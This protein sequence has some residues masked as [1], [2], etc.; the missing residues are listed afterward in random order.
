M[1]A[2]NRCHKRHGCR[3]VHGKQLQ[4]TCARLVRPRHVTRRLVV[5]VTIGDEQTMHE[6][7]CHIHVFALKKN[8]A[9]D[10]VDSR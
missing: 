6:E 2:A 4:N 1:R 7:V 9:A 10:R 8:A 5:E 3:H